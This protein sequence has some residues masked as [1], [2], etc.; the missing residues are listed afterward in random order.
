MPRSS[1]PWTC[2]WKHGWQKVKMYFMLGLPGETA[3][4][5]EAIALLLE[6]D[7]GRG[8]PAAIADRDPCLVLLVRP[9]TAHAVAM[10]RPGA[11]RRIEEKMACLRG[12]LRRH[13]NLDLDFHSPGRSMIE[14]I[15]ARGDARVGDLL[16]EVF[17]RGEVFTA[18]DAHFPSVGLGG[19]LPSPGRCRFPL[20]ASAGSGACPGTSSSS[21]STRLPGRG[22]P[23][24]PQRR[25]DRRLRR[26]GLRSCAGCCF[27]QTGS[28]P[29]AASS[30]DVRPERRRAARVPPAAYRRLRLVY[31]KKGDLRY[32][33]HLAM[34][35]FLERALRK[36]GLL[37]KYSAGIPPAH[38]DGRPAA[39]AG[40]CRGTGRG[41]RGPCGRQPE[42]R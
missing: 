42:L 37:F 27:G 4:D 18:W 2:A 24:Q 22:V 35:Q 7:P 20:R 10:G 31:E 33:S 8:P 15:L 40:R 25:G 19:S 14:T 5:V 23:A 39:A 26:T 30:R 34:M 12:R 36:S 41:D 13:K 17:R 29:P 28:P 21:I 1:R 38:Q 9:Q 32:L 11:C 16:L 3:E 6:R